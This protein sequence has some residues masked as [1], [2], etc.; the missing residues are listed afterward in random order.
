MKGE[1]L[2]CQEP[3]HRV[4]DNMRPPDVEVIEKPHRIEGHFAPVL[5]R[6]VRL[7]TPAVTAGVKR[8]HPV[9]SGQVLE[10]TSRHPGLKTTSHAVEQNDGLTVSLLY[11]TDCDPVGVE[12]FVL[13][14]AG[15]GRQH[16]T[17]NCGT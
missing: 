5:L 3:T 11:V 7:A 1:E 8:D 10:D 12:E 4:A 13:C 2:G 6:I 15:R 17:E 16:Q 14:K 9:V